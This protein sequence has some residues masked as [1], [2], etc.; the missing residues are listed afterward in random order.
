MRNI[1]IL[2][3]DDAPVGAGHYVKNKILGPSS[4]LDVSSRPFHPVFFS[5]PPTLQLNE[6]VFSSNTVILAESMLLYSTL[7]YL[8]DWLI[9]SL[10][11]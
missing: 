8:V 4:F 3:F 11:D 10:V 5:N 6:S 2:L 7:N 9:G 1:H